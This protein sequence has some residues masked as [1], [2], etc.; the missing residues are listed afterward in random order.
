MKLLVLKY[1][2][3]LNYI[4][5]IINVKPGVFDLWYGFIDGDY[6]TLHIAA[7]SAVLILLLGLVLWLVKSTVT[8]PTLVLTFSEKVI[9][10]T[11]WG[12]TG[13]FFLIVGLY[14]WLPREITLLL[15]KVKFMF[16][17]VS[18]TGMFVSI[19]LCLPLIVKGERHKFFRILFLEGGP[20]K[21]PYQ[22]CVISILVVYGLVI[23]ELLQNFFFFGRFQSIGVALI[24]VNVTLVIGRWLV[25]H[26]LIFFYGHPP[27][28]LNNIKKEAEV[29]KY[30]PP[31]LQ[32][33]LFKPKYKTIIKYRPVFK[34]VVVVTRFGS[35]SLLKTHNKKLVTV[36]CR[37][38]L[39]SSIGEIFHDA[40][41]GY[42]VMAHNPRYIGEHYKYM[43]GIE[44]KF[45]NKNNTLRYYNF[46]DQDTIINLAMR[47]ENFVQQIRLV[48]Q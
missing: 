16:R 26:N 15:C 34:S 21:K 33:E 22:R 47:R 29:A 2:T 40:S 37:N 20:L 25:I 44:Q 11:A 18:Y 6:S 9:S 48:S 43:Q 3:Y 36:F 38:G 8:H 24:I 17:Y 13:L 12:S 30:V 27:Y 31:R 23:E 10:V 4:F 41:K 39:W 42:R 14:F 7:G 35:Q 32:V 1:T 5:S 45:Y 19:F 46:L 28:G